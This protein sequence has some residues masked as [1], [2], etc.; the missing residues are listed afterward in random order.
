MKFLKHIIKFLFSSSLTLILWFYFDDITNKI[1]AILFP[2]KTILKELHNE[3]SQ[4]SIN[5]TQKQKLS[6]SDYILWGDENL[7]EQL[8]IDGIWNTLWK[9]FFKSKNDI[10][11]NNFEKP[12]FSTHDTVI[13]TD[14]IIKETGHNSISHIHKVLSDYFQNNMSWIDY[15]I[16]QGFK[17]LLIFCFFFL[18][19]WLITLC[20]KMYVKKGFSS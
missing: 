13:K 5:Y 18:V 14:N 2:K 17:M 1:R 20:F 12:S 3:I 7:K 15:L 16:I 9:P 4:K 8:K 6:W 19:Y 10:I 11:Q